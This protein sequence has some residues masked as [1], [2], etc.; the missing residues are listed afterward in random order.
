[1]S[2]PEGMLDPL[3]GCLL[4]LIYL[5]LRHVLGL[6]TEVL[7][8]LQATVSVSMIRLRDLLVRGCPRRERMEGSF[9]ALDCLSGIKKVKHLVDLEVAVCSSW[10]MTHHT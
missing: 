7:Q 9:L 3:H 10:I 5:M 8:S 4:P 2:S 1:M 6:I